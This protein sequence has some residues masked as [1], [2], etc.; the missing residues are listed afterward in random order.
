ISR[1]WRLPWLSYLAPFA[2]A[3]G[4]LISRLWRCGGPDLE[5]DLQTHPCCTTTA[6]DEVVIQK[7]SCGGV[8]HV[9]TRQAGLLG[10]I[11]RIE[12][13]EA[14]FDLQILAQPENFEETQVEVLHR[15]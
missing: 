12:R 15:L 13:L 6:T 7:S 1:L 2:L 8:R 10:M 3:P 14:I 5:D 11:E 9:Q 4:C